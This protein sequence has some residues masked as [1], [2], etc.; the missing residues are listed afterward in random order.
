GGVL[1][2]VEELKYLGILFTNEGRKEREIDR[3]I[4]AAFTVKQVLYRSVKVSGLSLRYRVRS[5]VIREGLRVEPLLLHIE[6][7]HLRWLGM[8]HWE[9]TP[10]KTQGMLE[11]LCFSTILGTPWDSPRNKWLRRN[12]G[13]PS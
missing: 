13:L 11:G 5:S 7:S 9:E 4:G 10:V 3:H 8:S 2:Q 6:R 12:L 1:P